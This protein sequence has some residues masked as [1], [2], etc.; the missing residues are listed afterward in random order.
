M[1][2]IHSTAR[3]LIC[4]VLCRVQ[5][6]TRTLL[7]AF[8]KLVVDDAREGQFWQRPQLLHV[9][10]RHPSFPCLGSSIPQGVLCQEFPLDRGA[11]LRLQGCRLG[12]NGYG[13]SVSTPVGLSTRLSISYGQHQEGLWYV[14]MIYL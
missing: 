9:V 5:S 3:H 13:V 10:L 2:G 4:L 14:D 6:A 11:D 7:G 12:S 8:L 1:A